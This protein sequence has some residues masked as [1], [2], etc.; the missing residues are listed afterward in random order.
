MPAFRLAVAALVG[1]ALWVAACGSAGDDNAAPLSRKASLPMDSRLESLEEKV[2]STRE[3]FP[4]VPTVDAGEV[5]R[6]IDD[7]SAVLV[8]VREPHERAV[9]TLPG[10]ISSDEFEKRSAEFTGRQVVTYCTVGYR[11]SKYA[12]ALMRK[13]WDVSNFEGSILA[14][15]HAGGTLVDSEGEETRR[16]HVFGPDWNLA[17]DG[18]EPVW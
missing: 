10:A 13:G 15:T 17:A 9:S 1:S 18:Y 6:R 8:D 3:A 2:E 7:G 16:V 4:D 5:A 11:S 12:R 14:W